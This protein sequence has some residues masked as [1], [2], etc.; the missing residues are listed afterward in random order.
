MNSRAEQEEARVLKELLEKQGTKEVTTTQ[1]TTDEKV[2]ARITDG[3]Y[4]LPSSALRELLANAYDADATEVVIQTDAPRFE[5]II[6]R[7][8]GAGMTLET[9]AHVIHHIGG[10]AKR[11][12][13]GR[14]LALV[15][16][17]DSELSP[18]GRPLI[19]KIGIGLFSVAQI[20]R[21][22]RIITKV[23]GERHRSIAEVILSQYGEETE[24]DKSFKP[25][26]VQIWSELTSDQNAHG[27]E[28][29]LFDIRPQT[30]KQL[31]S[32]EDWVLIE[33]QEKQAEA[34]DEVDSPTQPPAFH[35]GRY[36]SDSKTV[37]RHPACVP[38]KQEDS[39]SEKF[40][41]LVAGVEGLAQDFSTPELTKCLDAYL[42][43]VWTL[44]L[45]L[46]LP[47]ETKHPFDIEESDGLKL[48]LLSNEPKGQPQELVLGVGQ[49]V[50][51]ALDLKKKD[52]KH[53]S[54]FVVLID[55]LQLCRPIS[56]TRIPSHKN[57]IK[58][59]HIFYGRW[60]PDFARIPK[61][62]RGGEL[63]FE[64]YL[65]WAPKVVPK[66]HQGVLIRVRNASGTLFDE[67]FLKYKV[68]EQTRLRQITAEIFVH[69]GLDAALNIDRES[70]N[71]SHTHYLAIQQWLH[72]ALRQVANTM[73]KVG[74][75][76]R[77]IEHQISADERVST[78]SRVVKQ[79]W[80]SARSSDEEEPPTVELLTRSR[81][82]PLEIAKADVVLE[83]SVIYEDTGTMPRTAKRQEE[84]TAFDEK[85]KGIYQVLFAYRVFEKMDKKTQESLMRAIVRVLHADD[86]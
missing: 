80:K 59:A 73:K 42:Y 24:S 13:K 50:R 14:A 7:D 54:D 37:S 51:A 48:H 46:P 64:A 69:K 62:Q 31:Q 70:F 78:I 25:G 40:K 74:G 15:D 76:I 38:W 85:V 72:G 71:Y 3:I 81:T 32:M 11:S 22:F 4:R 23:A 41:E 16:K 53:L 83:K 21:H 27:T 30:K 19:G 75:T 79:E 12:E 29:E 56:L 55:D 44:A 9:L 77:K 20:T 8:N 17:K 47:Y 66:E 82:R 67:S 28:I 36:E 5:Q 6:V 26:T 10:S 2:I 84:Q 68:S 60:T 57:A 65:R 52:A 61:A 35:I 34:G 1:L 63:T 58:H 18:K 86:K 33:E 45:S 49:M 39:P 43:M